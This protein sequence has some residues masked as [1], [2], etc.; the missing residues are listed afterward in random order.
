MATET[1][2]K[3]TN[4]DRCHPLRIPPKLRL[5]IYDNYFGDEKECHVYWGWDAPIDVCWLKDKKDSANNS[6]SSL[7]LTCKA[8]YI[9]ASP[10]DPEHTAQRQLEGAK[11]W[12]FL[13]S[14]SSVIIFFYS[15]GNLPYL[16]RMETIF[17]DMKQCA[18]VKQ[19]LVNITAHHPHPRV[20]TVKRMMSLLRGLECKGTVRLAFDPDSD[21]YFT[22]E[23][24]RAML[25]AAKAEEAEHEEA[26]YEA[27]Q[28]EAAKDEAVW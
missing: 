15:D 17:E 20:E 28:Y 9:E 24:R 1:I 7:L 4:E 22:V 16:E 3:A 13:T 12:D 14:L 25:A 19:L 18:N 8:I 2:T 27:A 23:D 10:S 6:G 26:Q 5:R 21:R 11:Q